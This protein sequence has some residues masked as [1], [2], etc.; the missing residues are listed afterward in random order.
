MIGLVLCRVEVQQTR[1]CMSNGNAKQIHLKIVP[2][3]YICALL[4]DRHAYSI[5]ESETKS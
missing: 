3:T 1:K 4:I 5:D 2:H